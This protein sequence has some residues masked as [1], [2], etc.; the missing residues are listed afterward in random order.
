LLFELAV[1]ALADELDVPARRLRGALI[2]FL[3]RVRD[4][5]VT[6]DVIKEVLERS[7]ETPRWA[8]ADKA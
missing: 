4:S 5:K 1:F 6:F 2:P 7:N 8:L 3:V